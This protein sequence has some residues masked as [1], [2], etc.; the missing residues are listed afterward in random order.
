MKYILRLSM[1]NRILCAV[2][3]PLLGVLIGW[4][5]GN[6]IVTLILVGLGM[7]FGYYIVIVPTITNEYDSN[8]KVKD[9]SGQ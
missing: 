3:V 1:A 9:G 5:I 4:L 7:I 6:D 8:G 2:A